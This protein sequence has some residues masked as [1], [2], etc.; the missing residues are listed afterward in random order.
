LASALNMVSSGIGTMTSE[1][2]GL[3][4][5]EI[6]AL[7]QRMRALRQELRAQDAIA[8]ESRGPV[9][10]DQQSV[11]RLSRMDALQQQAMADAEARRRQND[12]ARIGAALRRI[13]QGEYGWCSECGEPI[14]K[15]RLE[16]DPMAT[17]C[18]RCAD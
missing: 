8:A 9:E 12:L 6:H 5:A 14:G 4:E 7:A 10:L 11:G 1:A 3:T 16:A 2:D 17:R 13:E 18:I 15:R